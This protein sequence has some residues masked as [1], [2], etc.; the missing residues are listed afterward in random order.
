MSILLATCVMAASLFALWGASHNLGERND[1]TYITLTYAKSLAAGEG[2]RYNGGSETLGTTAP[3]FALFMA[4]LARLL[5][6]IPLEH[7][8]VAWSTVCWIATA[9]LLFLGHRGFGL[10]QVEGMLLALAALLQGGWWFIALGMEM[11]MLLFGLTLTIWLAARGHA[12]LSGA[13]S[14]SLFL[15]RPEGIGVVPLTAGW[16]LW[17][18]REEWR[19]QAPRFLLGATLPLLLW[20]AYA[21]PKFGSLLP[22]SAIAK[23][24]QGDGWPGN[25]FIERLLREWLPPYI[26]SYGLS[27]TLSLVWPLVALGMLRTVRHTRPMLLFAAWLAVFLLAYALLGAPGYW[28]Y[29]LPVLFILQLF[30]TLGLSTLLVRQEA[31]FRGL[32]LLLALLF[33]GTS[34]QIGVQGIEKYTGDPRAST[35]HNAASWLNEHAPSNSNVASIEIGYLGYFT[36]H[37]IVDLA[38]L[39]MPDFT[40][41]ANRL[42][43]ATNFWQVEPDYLL[44]HSAFDWALGP[45]TLDPRFPTH[46]RP[47][48]ELPSHWGSPLQ[49]YKRVGRH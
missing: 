39:T 46:Y 38:G 7:L 48:A 44:Y 34:L 45:I 2:W 31:W 35:Y 32:G 21:L 1:D 27:T 17:R 16:L 12:F 20:A 14:A 43:F 49:V 23:L 9:W 18:H 29:T 11:S 15:V 22:N 41:N 6:T 25:S 42:D 36:D 19:E 24:G 8:A 26:A 3:L 4:G 10:T 37:H 47:V 28:W 33:L 30:V 13:V 40:E 5:P